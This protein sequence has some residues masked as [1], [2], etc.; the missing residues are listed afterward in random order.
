MKND[1]TN[2]D[3]TQLVAIPGFP[4][5]LANRQ[6]EVWSVH[7]KGRVPKGSRFKYLD[8]CDANKMK[9]WRDPGGYLHHTLVDGDPRTRCRIPLHSLI[10]RTFLG[11]RPPG[12]VVAHLDGNKNNN[13]VN[14]LKYLTQR[15]NV[16]QKR[17]H[18]TMLCGD[19]SHMSRLTD[20]EC[21]E[22][23]FF[24]D[25]GVSRREVA[26]AYGVSVSHVYALRSGR[27]RK[28]LTNSIDALISPT[29]FERTSI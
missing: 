28:H 5:Y 9:R 17:V 4:G 22:I 29:T 25:E 12:L 27:I 2:G 19:K 13:H 15:E 24:L 23:L 21:R 14:N 18:G 6:G 8:L 20:A 26:Q 11:P 3:E 7:R 16:N 1:R 10:A